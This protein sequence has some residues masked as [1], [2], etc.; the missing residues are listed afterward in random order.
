MKN[1]LTSF[2]L[3]MISFSFTLHSCQN[4]T[5][6]EKIETKRGIIVPIFDSLKFSEKY[7]C[8]LSPEQGFSVYDNPKGKII[9]KLKRI[10]NAKEDDQV[11]YKIYLIT[12][13]KKVEIK[14]F[15]QIDYEIFAINYTD[16]SDGFVKVL[17]T[18][19]NYW[20]SVAEIEK[21]GFKTITWR[22]Q[23]IKESENTLGYYANEPGLRLR[24]EP[25]SESEIMGSVRGDLFE[26]KLTKTTSGQWCKVKV[27]KY[28][29]HLCNTDLEEAEN[30]ESKTE[31][32]LKIID[33]NG[34][35]NLWSYTRGC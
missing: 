16:S 32:W 7:C 30:I 4:K 28:K 3:L 14:N 27:I 1:T 5:E 35:P 12:G 6:T 25:N 11:P 29:E 21:H 19:K 23:M 20:L 17:D 9:G 34:E 18:L 31:G 2:L 8:I 10:G 24:K 26:I 15:R 13:E 22:D 33:D